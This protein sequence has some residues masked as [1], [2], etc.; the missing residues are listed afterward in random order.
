MAFDY[1]HR[2]FALTPVRR[3][4]MG[5]IV[6]RKSDVG[7]VESS[8]ILGQKEGIFRRREC[9]EPPEFVSL[10]VILIPA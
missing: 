8:E 6:V 1:F 10:W 3:D 2:G 9:Q 5:V 7:S 4:R